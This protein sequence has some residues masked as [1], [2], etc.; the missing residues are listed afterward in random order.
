M[1]K[2]TNLALKNR[3]TNLPNLKNKKSYK[4]PLFFSFFLKKG[5]PDVC[6]SIHNLVL[7]LN[8]K[9]INYQHN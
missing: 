8:A 1:S 6:I 4:N 5:F 2:I 7:E 3:I 9:N